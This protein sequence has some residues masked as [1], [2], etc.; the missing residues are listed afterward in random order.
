MATLC[1]IREDG[2]IG[3]RWELRG[4]PL[5]VGRDEAADAHIEDEATS[6]RHAV[7]FREGDSYIIEDLG[8]QN[9]TWV[10][11]RRL[12]AARLY[13]NAQIL[14]GRTR[15]VFLDRPI[16]TVTVVQTPQRLTGSEV[17]VPPAPPR[18]PVPNRTGPSFAKQP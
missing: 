6:R 16:P 14:I 9:G 15:F 7:I 11:G 4:Q 10:D 12:L 17:P 1:Q 3:E 2:S 18:L 5:V 8:S 13:H